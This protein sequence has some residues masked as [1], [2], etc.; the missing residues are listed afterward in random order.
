MAEPENWEQQTLST[1]TDYLDTKGID[2]RVDGDNAIFNCPFC[3]ET[4]GKFGINIDNYLGQCFRNSCSTKVNEITFKRKFNDTVHVSNFED[5][6][7]QVGS[8][9]KTTTS[10]EPIP[11]IEAAHKK[12]LEDGLVLN[13]L[14]DERGFSLETIKRAKL[15]LCKRIFG[16][17]G[18]DPEI[19]ALMFPYFAKGKCVGIKF[20]AL[21]PAPKDFRFSAGWDVGLYNED[22]ITPGMESLIICEGETDV[23]TLLNQG[24]TNVVGISGVKGGKVEF[25]DKLEL[26]GTKMYLLLDNDDAGLKGVKDFTER[27][28]ADRFHVV[29]IPHEDLE[30]P[31][32]DK[33][34]TRTTINDVNE[35]FMLHHTVEDFNG[36]LAAARP[37]DIEGVTTMSEAF[38]NIRK[39]L[40]DTGTLAPEYLFKWP[41]ITARA[42]GIK[43]GY[44]IVTLAAPKCGKTTWWLNQCEFMAEEYGVNPHLDVMEMDGEDLTLKWSAMK[45]EVEEDLLTEA[46]IEQAEMIDR[47]RASH[48]NFTRSNPTN[49]DDYLQKLVRIKRR[50]DSGII[51]IDNFQILIDLT[52]GKGNTNNRPSY[53]SMVSKKL[54]ALAG[55]LRTPIGIVS[56]PRNIGEGEM[57]TIEHSEGSGT[58]KADADLFFTFNRNPEAKMKMAQ[59]EAIGNMQ[60]NQS[61]S[62][63]MYV[64]VGLSRGSAGGRTT[65]K[66]DG[67]KSIIREWNSEEANANTHKVL[68]NGIKI[69]NEEETTQI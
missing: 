1:V 10:K 16:K 64:D 49:L 59:L 66:I 56:Q 68:V 29:N 43:K 31:I 41:T 45:L 51:V 15:G 8:K 7:A 33:H 17:R 65:L 24:I 55:E 23:L 28:G 61:H 19:P 40:K 36:L 35:Y 52:I 69:V 27:F 38:A 11:D 13:Y 14:N 37:V 6:V 44:F 9:P 32:V 25:A 54:K 34:G 12:L 53:M 63:N 67:A 48:F 50:Y 21:P 18:V 47:F 26:P 30:E 5:E 3:G 60:T 46:Q 58:L 39:K 57:V 62:D 20:K 4:E 42:K 2:Y 22:A